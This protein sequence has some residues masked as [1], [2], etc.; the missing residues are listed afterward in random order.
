M[1]KIKKLICLS[2][3]LSLIMFASSVFAAKGSERRVGVQA[4]Q[5]A[6]GQS[7]FNRVSDWFATVGK[8]D[9]EKAKILA[10]RRT[11]RAKQRARKDLKEAVRKGKAKIINSRMDM[12]K[13]KELIKQIREQQ[14]VRKTEAERMQQTGS[15]ET[16]GQGQGNE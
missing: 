13:R 14:Q 6:G 3:A 10:E 8:S 1:C 16:V 9:Q 2:V 15:Q 11:K 12:R 7:I 4:Y 5:N